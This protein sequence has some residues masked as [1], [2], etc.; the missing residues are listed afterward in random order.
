MWEAWNRR[1]SS[2]LAYVHGCQELIRS[3]A[4]FPLSTPFERPAAWR[5][6][7]A[8]EGRWRTSTTSSGRSVQTRLRPR[9]EQEEA[10]A[11]KRRQQRHKGGR[12]RPPCRWKRWRRAPDNEESEARARNTEA[13]LAGRTPPCRARDDLR[14]SATLWRVRQQVPATGRAQSSAA[15]I[16]A[17]RAPR[18]Q[19]RRRDRRR[20]RRPR[21]VGGHPPRA[22]RRAPAGR[23]ARRELL[24]LRAQLDTA[25]AEAQGCATI[26]AALAREEARAT[27]DRLKA[28]LV[29]TQAGLEARAGEAAAA[30]AAA[31][32]VA[33]GSRSRPSGSH[34]A[35]RSWR[36]TSASWRAC[37]TSSP[38]SS[39][40]PPPPPSR[41]STTTT[42]PGRRRA[43]ARRRGAPPPPLPA[44]AAAEWAA[45][46]EA[47]RGARRRS[48]RSS[49]TSSAS[50]T[51]RPRGR[52]GPQPA[53]RA[54]TAHEALNGAA[55]G[56]GG[57]VG[58]DARRRG[59]RRPSRRARRA[60]SRCL[61]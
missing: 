44:L 37:A 58:G 3:R 38:P 60:P 52:R 34:G 2:V 35:T 39:R 26:A 46:V 54:A 30:A 22:D 47:L 50:L 20:C 8:F 4:T 36:R 21:L 61:A 31:M 28:E 6:A 29:A 15:R 10:A 53:R 14:L 55:R 56:R 12:L 16:G 25:R 11:V 7:A 42:A 23:R 45:K 17:A 49:A 5:T 48:R 33:R 19:G 27:A 43:T 59:A 41:P 13:L 51:P 32:A 9:R 1:A 18:G 40:A 57:G 24:T